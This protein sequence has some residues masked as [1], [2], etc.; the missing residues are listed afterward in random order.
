MHREEKVTKDAIKRYNRIAPI[1]DLMESLV[2][3]SRYRK[4]REILW[5]KVEGTSILEVGVGTGKNFPYYPQGAHVTAVDFSDKMLARARSKAKKQGLKID[6][7]QMD[8][9]K[10]EF[11]DNTFD[12]VVAS[13]VFCSVPDP[14][15]GLKEIK[16]ICKP[17]GKVLLLEHVLS[18]NRILAFLMN[19]V[20]PVVVRV[21]GPNINR[22][23]VENVHNSGL[24]IE[25]VT[26]LAAGIFKL[27]EARK[28]A[29]SS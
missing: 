5:S 28:E 26:D 24:N 18:A 15:K 8:V 17:G 7:R 16:R 27:I 2:E 23:T 6:L 21:M 11:K 1:Y 20:N 19:L 10:L 4:W 25:K 9:Q 14:I 29:T 22:K 13:F 12:T 3:R